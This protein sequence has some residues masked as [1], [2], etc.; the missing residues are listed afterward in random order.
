MPSPNNK[1][2]C[3]SS[4]GMYEDDKNNPIC[5]D[6]CWHKN[7]RVS[8]PFAAVAFD[9]EVIIIGSNGDFYYTQSGGSLHKDRVTKK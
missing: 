5:Q 6:V 2:L 7:D 9:Q 8:Q 4:C 3:P 1:E